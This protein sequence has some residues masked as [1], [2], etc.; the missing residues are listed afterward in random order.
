MRASEF[1]IA[2][3][4]FHVND[5]N[6]YSRPVLFRINGGLNALRGLHQCVK[7]PRLEMTAYAEQQLGA[8]ALQR[9][10]LGRAADDDL[11]ALSIHASADPADVSGL[12]FITQKFSL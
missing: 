7:M 5:M 2:L 8:Q 4:K 10:F 11:H 9:A 3:S 1:T 6:R 12:D